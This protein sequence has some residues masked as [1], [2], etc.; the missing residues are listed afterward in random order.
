MSVVYLRADDLGRALTEL[1]T[2]PNPFAVWC[3]QHILEMHGID[4]SEL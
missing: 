2:S 3:R 4:L 1:A